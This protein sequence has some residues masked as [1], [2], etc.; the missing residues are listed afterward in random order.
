MIRT[1][2]ARSNSM[3]P[4]ISRRL[5]STATRATATAAPH[6]RTSE[7]W[8]AVRRTSIVV[9]P[10]WRL[11]VRMLST[12]SALRPNIL[13][14]A[15][16]PQHV[17]EEGAEPVDLGEPPLRDG[18]RP[19]ADEPEQQDE[20]RPGQDQDQRRRRVDDEDRGE[21][22]QRDG[23]GQ[24]PGRLERRQVGID[25]VHPVDDDPGQLAG[26]LASRPGR[27]EREELRGQRLAQAAT[28][29]RRGA[30]R[31]DVTRERQPAPGSPPAARPRRGPAR[32]SPATRR[33]GR[34]RRPRRSR[35]TPGRPRPRPPRTRTP[36]AAHSQRPRTRRGGQQPRLRASMRER[37][38]RSS[39]R[40]APS[41][42]AGRRRSCPGRCS[43]RRPCRAART[44]CR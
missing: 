7:V 17:E 33:Q 12:C 43:T 35:G 19:A 25:V 9:S 41:S 44:A 31:E 29:Q 26:P 22:E 37:P 39:G 10:Y 4:A 24:R 2:S 32:P 11:I 13:S 18:P 40:R 21:H 42:R 36:M 1:A 3:A 16:P 14:V 28:R 6:S 34:R 20:D 27:P 23:H 15:R 8:N 38:R 30:L 5:I